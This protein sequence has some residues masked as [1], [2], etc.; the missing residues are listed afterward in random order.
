VI[1][2]DWHDKFEREMT[3]ARAARSAGNEGQ[4][5]VC[6]RRAAGAVAGEYLRRQGIAFASPSAYDRLEFIQEQPETPLH[7]R[8]LAGRLL[9]RVDEDHNLPGGTDLIADAEALAQALNLHA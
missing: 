8:E 2:Q 9:L 6:A 7:V 5:R 3:R 1:V 4:A